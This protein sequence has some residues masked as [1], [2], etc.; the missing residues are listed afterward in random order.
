[1]DSFFKDL[2]IIELASVLAGPTVGLFFAE[3]GATVIKIENKRTGGDVTRQWKLPVEDPQA[4]YSAYYCSTNWNKK[5]HFLDL[6]AVEDRQKV[7]GWAKHADIILTNFRAGGAEKLGM[8][9]STFAKIN[10]EIIYA[11][12]TGF[13]AHDR[14]PA[15]DVV[16]QAEAGFMFMCGPEGGPPVKMPVALIDLLAAHQLKEGILMALIQRYKTGKGSIV[17]SSLYDAALGS[18]ANQATNWL[19]AGHIPQAIGAKHPNIAPYGDIFYCQDGRAL[20]L[21]VGNDKQFQV[22][23]TCLGKS[24]LALDPRFSENKLRVKNRDALVQSL[25]PFFKM[26]DRNYWMER[27]ADHAVPAGAIKN[28]KEVFEDPAAQE[29]ILEEQMVDGGLSRRVKTVA[30][31]VLDFDE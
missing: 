19:M 28:M 26:Q 21:A 1:M 6:R 10:P 15:F 3:L 29:R 24:D 8:D 16:L 7:Y 18:L 30:V 12:L 27:F 13:G 17:R 4:P 5:T 20:V 23:C 11:E 14:R 2:T 25:Q 22:L 31:E 9:A